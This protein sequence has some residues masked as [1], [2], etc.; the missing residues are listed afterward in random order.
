MRRHNTC[1]L[2][3]SFGVK[4][5]YAA[6]LVLSPAILYGLA[7]AAA[8]LASAFYRRTCPACG[9]R[10]LKCVN[11]I[12]ATVL[13]DGHRAP[14]YWSYYVCELCGAGYKLHHGNW[15]AVGAEEIRQGLPP[16]RT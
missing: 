4:W 10:G 1:V 13:V 14:D 16:R 2:T 6:M 5:M 11:F 7:L 15:L 8:A 9:R 12:R 3:E